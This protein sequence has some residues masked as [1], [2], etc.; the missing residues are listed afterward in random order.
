MNDATAHP[1]PLCRRF[2]RVGRLV[3]D[4]GMRML[5]RAHV[6]IVGIG[7][8][9][10]W[11]AEALAR[12]GVGTLTLVDFDPVCI[13]NFNRQ[14]HAVEGTVGTPKTEVMA[15]RLRAINPEIVV[16]T[17]PVFYSAECADEVFTRRPDHVIDAIDSVGAKC[18]LLHY[19]VSR[20]IPVV[21]S[22]GSGGR[23]DPTRIEVCDLSVTQHDRLAQAVR[24]VLRK[25]HGFP[26]AGKGL[27]GI[28]AVHSTEPMTMPLALEYDEGKGFR[29]VCK[30][31][32]EVFNCES[33]NV[34]MGTICHV[35]GA[36]GFA[37]A[38]VAVR[39]LLAD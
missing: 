15:Q 10:S 5:A 7:G 30:S 17:L 37:C 19:C 2:D 27:F 4:D 24:K 35:T 14:I 13:T 38:S 22:Y 29:C 23:M 21:S 18:H 6:M 25:Q 8:V 33:R 34:I 32:I 28:P 16:H 9:G 31:R 3:G 39:G 20:G 36:F 12:S 11:A 1:A 26:A